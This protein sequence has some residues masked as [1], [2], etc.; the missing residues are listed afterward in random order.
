MVMAAARPIEEPLIE[1]LPVVRGLYEENAELGKRSWFRTGGKVEVL[2][3]PADADD[4][5]AFMEARPSDV[6][7]T[8]VGFGS[9][10]LIRDGGVDGVVIVLGKSFARIE[11]DGELITAGAAALDVQVARSAQQAGV[12]G[13]E[14]LAG[15]PGSIGGAVRMNAGAYG[16]EI[17]DVI[18]NATVLD[19]QGGA[20]VLDANQLELGYRQSGLKDDW[21]VLSA[22]LRGELGDP[23]EIAGRMAAISTARIESQPRTRTGGSTFANPPGAKAWELIDQAGCRG[24]R[25]GGAMVSEQHCN[26]LLNLGDATSGDLELLGEEIRCRVLE[27][28][29]VHLEWEIRRIGKARQ[30]DML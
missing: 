15:I 11:F 7:L 16:S 27:Q 10:L 1:R 4:L 13:L 5:Q 25:R 22:R 20:H 17:G 8:I 19:E 24:L 14:F 6:D 29:G 26:F 18:T 2:F 12:A 3:Q 28:T 30:K 23:D 9:N 21:I